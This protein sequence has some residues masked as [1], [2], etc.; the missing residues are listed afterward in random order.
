MAPSISRQE[1]RESEREWRDMSEL[2]GKLEKAL[3]RLSA[4]TP[5]E[6]M[7]RGGVDNLPGKDLP[8]YAQL[9]LDVA[10]DP[11]IE[12]LIASYKM[13]SKTA[14]QWSRAY[15]LALEMRGAGMVDQK[16]DRDNAMAET[17]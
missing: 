5:E 3:A 16:D 13:G 1:G 9:I 11:K 7:K 4:W 17:A 14:D 10:N 12:K 15:S 8:E 2:T 6:V